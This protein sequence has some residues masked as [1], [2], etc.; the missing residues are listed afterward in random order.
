MSGSAAVS[1]IAIRA[2]TTADVGAI[3]AMLTAAT[4]PVVGVADHFADFMVAERSGRLVGAIGLEVYGDAAL[5]RSA[6]TAPDV[7]GSGVGRALVDAIELRAAALGVRELI[8]LT[9]TAQDWFPRFGYERIARGAAPVAVTASTEFQGACPASA[10]AM[11]KRLPLP[12][13]ALASPR[14]YRVLILCTGNSARSQIAEALLNHKGAGRFHAESA[15]SRPAA[16]VNPFAIDALARAGVPWHGHAPRGLDGLD[17]EPW[18]FVITVCDNAKESCPILPGHPISAH[19][20]M[21]DP[22]E[23]TGTDHDKRRAFDE[24]VRVINRRLDLLLALPID[25]VDRMLLGERM[26]AIGTA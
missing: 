8:L 24:T 22:A 10:I 13:N 4:L 12:V 19:W 2:A 18:D 26:A 9:E 7:R 14:A 3:K 5:L 1:E 15:G 20:G 16:R 21:P 6:V 23:V 11:R 25:H 17:R